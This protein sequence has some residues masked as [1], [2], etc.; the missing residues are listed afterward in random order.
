VTERAGAPA[1]TGTVTFLFS[2][3]EGSTERWDRDRSA[4][5]HAVRRHDALM[6]DII[7]KNTGTVF[8]TVGDAFCAAFARP[9][10]GIAAAVEVQRALAAEDL[11]SV[12]GLRVRMG[13]H[14][15]TADERGGDYF[16]PTVNRVARL[17]A[18]GHGGQVLVS[19]VTADLARATLP[20]D[21]TLEDL[22]SRRLKDLAIPERVFQVLV[23]GLPAAF[24][25][26]LSLDTPRNNLPL[27]LTNFIGRS[28]EI[29][30]LS[31]RLEST[32]L[33]TLVGPSGVG[34]TRLSLQL[35]AQLLERFP[36]GV[37]FVDLAE[38]TEPEQV[39]REVA[40]AAGAY[41]SANRPIAT[42]VVAALRYNRTLLIVDNCE[43]LVAAVAS[44]IDVILRSCPDVSVIATS[45]Q[46]LDISREV[47]HYV[48]PLALPDDDDPCTVDNA[49]SYGAVQLFVDRA[50]A[51]NTL[52]HGCAVLP[53]AAV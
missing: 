27:Q 12:D 21:V 39:A 49:I 47:A 38:R 26:L 11:S 1:P 44:L 45:R 46:A 4:M 5:Q 52:P 30:D 24:P 42:S 36:D 28:H 16:G 23:P 14:T 17:M 35:A 37:W 22:G 32:R 10:D 9:E 34:K 51:A 41:V 2:D 19:G 33:L 15:G 7:V 6:H 48:E 13:I 25:P 3:I 8:K 53:L 18:I 40:T 29:E 20:R 50:Q 43:H 31:R